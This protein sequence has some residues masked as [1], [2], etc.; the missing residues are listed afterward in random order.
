M[1]GALGDERE[2]RRAE[3][4]ESIA[5]ESSAPDNG[6][7][8]GRDRVTFALRRYAVTPLRRHASKRGGAPSGGMVTGSTA[9]SGVGG[10]VGSVSGASRSVETSA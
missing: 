7:P 10:G 5:V 1:R 9:M 6:D 2:P 8:F 4:Y 3:R